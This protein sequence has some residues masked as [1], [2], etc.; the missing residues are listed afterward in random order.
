MCGFILALS[1]LLWCLP[2]AQADL[3]QWTDSEGVIH[4]V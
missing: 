4:V 3:Y 1:I 2:L